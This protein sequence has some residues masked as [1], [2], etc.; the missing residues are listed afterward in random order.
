MLINSHKRKP[1]SIFGRWTTRGALAVLAVVLTLTVSVG[2]VRAWPTPVELI[3]DT[4]PGVDDAAALAWLFSQRGYPVDVHGIVTTYGNTTDFTLPDGSV[5]PGVYFSTVNVLTLLDTMGVNYVPGEEDYVQ[6][7]MGTNES[8]SN[9]PNSLASAMLHGPDGLWGVG[10]ANLGNYDIQG[11]IMDGTIG[12]DP[13][14]FYCQMA[15]EHPGATVVTLGPLTNVALAVEQCPTE[16]QNFGQIVVTGGSQYAHAPQ[17]DYNI[18]QDPLAAETVLS[19]GIPVRMVLSET[20]KELVINEKDLTRLTNVGTPVAQLLL[21]PMQT[22]ADVLSQY[23]GKVEVELCDVATMMVAVDPW[24]VREVQPGLVKIEQNG[25]LTTGQTVIG[26]DMQ[27]K[28]NMIAS[29]EELNALITQLFN[30]DITQDEFM[31]ALGGILWQEPDNA[32]VV[33][34]IGDF[35]M[36]RYFMTA[37]TSWPPRRP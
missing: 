9:V 24:L 4:E 20:S 33:L 14:G 37:L 5:I 18:W 10:F 30:G 2:A 36:H 19:A 11:M 3:I 27:A 29:T 31:A 28:L 32:E 15:V 34:D 12:Y 8:L 16:M 25:D 13:A 1:R 6:V 22:F 26:L 17:S 7:V 21:G 23:S 35:W